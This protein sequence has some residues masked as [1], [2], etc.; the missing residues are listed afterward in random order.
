M[1]GC[2]HV[3]IQAQCACCPIS[4]PRP[5][6]L[7]SP[8]LES[9]AAVVRRFVEPYA[10][11]SA[12]KTTRNVRN[13]ECLIAVDNLTPATRLLREAPLAAVPTDGLRGFCHSCFM[14]RSDPSY[15]YTCEDCNLSGE[16]CS[17][18][19]QE[20]F[21][22]IHAGVEC[23]ILNCLSFETEEGADTKE[24]RLG[25][26]LLAT[27]NAAPKAMEMS[28]NGPLL[29]KFN[30][31][32]YEA[33]ADA[34]MQVC[35]SRCWGVLPVARRIKCHDLNSP[36]A[37]PSRTA[38]AIKRITDTAESHKCAVEAEWE[39]GALWAQ[40]WQHAWTRNALKQYKWMNQTLHHCRKKQESLWT[41]ARRERRR[42]EIK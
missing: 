40:P 21:K 23:D 6:T 3:G 9:P 38:Q 19:C 22:Q 5:S 34:L 8:V 24:L 15:S 7:V 41:A 4:A 17:S 36:G 12:L 13:E 30:L 28:A 20:R 2:R 26:R 18:E 25:I 33:W 29:P 35:C 14:E 42:G 1:Y 11:H 37:G 16:F 32:D 27:A 10:M 31:E 39:E